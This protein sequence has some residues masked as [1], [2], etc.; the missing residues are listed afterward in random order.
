M[1][2]PSYTP[3]P[4]FDRL[5]T[6]LRRGQP[7]RVPFIELFLDWPIMSAIREEPFSADPAQY[8]RQMA[9]LYR[10]L[11]YDYCPAQVSL[12]LP[13][14]NLR[15][16]DTAALP[17]QERSWVDEFHGAIE[18]WED[19]ERYPWPKPQHIDYRDIEQSAAAL[20]SGMKVVFIGPG[21]V[22]ENVMWLM[23]YAPFSYALADQP[24]LIEAMFDRVGSLLVDIFDTAASHE[25]V[26]ALWLGDDMGFKTHTM[27]SP[28]ALRRYVFPWQRRIAQ[29]VHA[30]GKPFLLHAC[31]NLDAVMEDLI[32]YVGID[33][34]HSFEDVITPVTEAKRRWG[35]RIAILGG[36][37]V[38]LLA[39]GTPE[40]VRKRTREIMEA[41]MP[42]GGFALGSGNSI[43]NYIPLDNYFAMLE[44]GWRLGVYS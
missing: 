7:D 44:E 1:P 33:G 38:D 25:A 24:D 26:G 16:Q 39:R 31:G 30:H 6:A 15:A 40:Q 5:N 29:A 14:K 2:Y 22:L 11:G 34:K 19:F 32:D 20:V 43:A 17:M 21:G 37:D 42:G 27:I 36:V 35:D 28:E 18:T 13:R 23:G 12:P 10:R 4:N 3:E 8:R 41:C 9:E